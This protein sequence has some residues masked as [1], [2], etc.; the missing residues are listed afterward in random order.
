MWDRV[1]PSNENEILDFKWS[2]RPI[3]NWMCCMAIPLVDI[4]SLKK[5]SLWRYVLVMLLSAACF[6]L[7]VG[8]NIFII[9]TTRLPPKNSTFSTTAAWNNIITSWNFILISVGTHTVLL[10]FTVTRWRHLMGIT[11]R[12]ECFLKPKNYKQFRRTFLFGLVF[13]IL[14]RKENGN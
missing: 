11:D 8:V 14:V 1:V 7:N 12:L 3:L 10:T 6:I 5:K 9:L 2:I 13:V 4:Q